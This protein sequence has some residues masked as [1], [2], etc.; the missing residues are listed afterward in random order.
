MLQ[1]WMLTRMLGM[2]WVPAFVLASPAGADRVVLVEGGAPR[3]AVILPDEPLPVHELAARELLYHVRQATGADLPLHRES[4]APGGAEFVVYIGPC[5]ATAEA[6]IDVETLPPSAHV[7][8]T[9]GNALFLAGR[10]RDRGGIGRWW[11]ADWQGTLFAVYDLLEIEL[12]VRWLWPGELG[13]HIPRHADV[14]VEGLDRQGA[15][16]FQMSTLRPAGAGG[17][18][19]PGWSSPESKEAFHEAQRVFLIRHRF[20][21]VENLGYGH[22]FGS[23]WR[24]HGET[25][26]EYFHLLPDGTR[27]PLEGD[28][29]GSYIT[30]CVSEP[31]FWN[32]IVTNWQ[33][34]PE[35]NPEHVPYRPRI[36]LCENDTPGMCTCP[37]CR[38][39]D[40]PRPS[41]DAHDYWGKGII[42]TS[43]RRFTIAHAPWGELPGGE[44]AR[45]EPPSLSD[46]YARFYVEVLR[47]A[48]EVDPEARAAGYAYANYTAP[49]VNQDLDLSGVLIVN[50]DAFWFPRVDLEGFRAHWEGWRRL[51]AELTWRPNLTHVGANLPLFYARPLADFFSFGAANGMIGTYFDS[52]QGAWSAQGPT[53]YVLSRIHH[54]PDWTVDRILDEYYAAFGPA[55]QGVRAYF[56]YWE[57]HSEALD[58]EDVARYGQE[59]KG[60]GFKNYVRI[61]HRLF[62]PE[63]FAAARAL[64]EQAREQAAGDALALR[65]IAF[66]EQG[67][68]DAELTTATRAAQARLEAEDTEEH[69]AAFD[70]AFNRLVDYRAVMEAGGDHPADLGYFAFREH[71]G[72]GWP[73]LRRASDEQLAAERGF[74]ARWPDIPARDPREAGLRLV[75][76]HKLPRTGWRFHKDPDRKGD[77]LG[78]HSPETDTGDWQEVQI[79]T[80]WEAF[81]GEPYVGAGWYR[82]TIEAP[83]LP[84]GGAACLQFGAVDE[85]CWVWV[86][87]EYV[88]RHH[89]GPEGWDAPFQLEVTPA[90][91]TG[92]NLII[93]RAMNTAWAGGV[94]RP[95]HLVI[96]GPAAGDE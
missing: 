47:R 49:P 9:V 82:R 20:G 76:R 83:V 15:P 11:T 4:D 14:V 72:S 84:E 18:H 66:L 26:P 22:A 74:Q 10:D 33:R 36:N 62:A 94:W 64:L 93:I 27:R 42:P 68:T 80:A 59:E 31:K 17:G 34:S 3:A 44:A 39:W 37:N 91:R 57:R 95:V 63:D 30:M 19:L 79:E 81:L 96:Y 40:A 89:R 77:T 78:W 71:H 25:H 46:R 53:M 67:L 38:A 65:R 28:A 69:R 16:R 51:G 21:A 41:F 70:D 35:R 90:L 13:E 58:P 45:L 75:A 23:Y 50:V 60:G 1:R 85:S 73:H 24:W 43:A 88:G 8:R 7:S 55:E 92:E 12:G 2:V 52:L 6:G 54:H 86:N 48:R 87:G 56:G 32:R 5:R 61:A 29:S